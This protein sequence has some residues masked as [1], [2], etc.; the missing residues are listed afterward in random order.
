VTEAEPPDD[1]FHRIGQ[2][3]ADILRTASRAADATRERTEA[4]ADALLAETRTQA[5][6]IL[7]EASAV[8]EQAQREADDVVRDAEQRAARLLESLRA[9]EAGARTHVEAAVAELHAMMHELERF[10]DTRLQDR[11]DLIIDLRDGAGQSAISEPRPA[12]EPD[13]HGID[14]EAR[15]DSLGRD[16]AVDEGHGSGT[17]G[18]SDLPPPEPDP[19]SAGAGDDEGEPTTEPTVAPE[20]DAAEKEDGAAVTHPPEAA[21]E[22]RFERAIRSGVAR[23]VSGFLGG[24]RRGDRAKHDPPEGDD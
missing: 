10:T 1:P 9:H 17:A 2:D 11:D 18:H 23:A 21:S 14:D 3:V 7:A 4:E 12:S 24:E 8:R 19:V 16:A 22:E 5:D 15:L 13:E 6:A 20:Q